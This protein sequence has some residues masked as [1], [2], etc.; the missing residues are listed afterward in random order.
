M[1]YEGS[2]EITGTTRNGVPTWTSSHDGDAC[3]I[4]IKIGEVSANLECLFRRHGPGMTVQIVINGDPA[5]TLLVRNLKVTSGFQFAPGAWTLNAPGNG[6]AR[7]TPLAE[8]TGWTGISAI[9][10]LRGS[11]AVLHLAGEQ[12]C[13]A[14]WLRHEL[15]VPDIRIKG[16]NDHTLA[17]ELTTNFAADLARVSVA[18]ID[19]FDLDL[20]VPEF[21]HFPEL[22]QT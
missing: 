7:N 8:V 3:R 16:V 2:S 5:S 12:T 18:S 19:L 15:E 10:G 1:D 4:P 6:V 22:F 17:L 21:L 14:L 20:R 9:G 13:A 11:S